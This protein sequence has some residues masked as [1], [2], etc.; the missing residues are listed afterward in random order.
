V[1]GGGA[2]RHAA[3]WRTTSGMAALPKTAP[4]PREAPLPRA[5]VREEELGAEGRGRGRGRQKGSEG[6]R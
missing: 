5:A 1:K 6:K 3:S 4:L 2:G